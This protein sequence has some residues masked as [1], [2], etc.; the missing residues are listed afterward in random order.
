MGR[1]NNEAVVWQVA[2]FRAC[3]RTPG[4]EDGPPAFQ[5][6]CSMR[7]VIQ[8]V[9]EGARVY[10]RSETIGVMYSALADK[11]QIGVCG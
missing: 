2:G 4:V 3:L 9:I 7:E 10:S 5:A 6:N 8:D 11:C 1:R